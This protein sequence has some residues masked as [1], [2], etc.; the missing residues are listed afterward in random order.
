[1]DLLESSIFWIQQSAHDAASAQAMF[2]ALQNKAFAL[3]VDLRT[4]PPLPTSCCGRGCNGCVW[5][6]FLHA[7]EF[8]RQSAWLV[9]EPYALKPE[10]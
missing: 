6:S 7:A 2:A 1:M 9:M 8:W 5:E 4:P 10:A 3:G